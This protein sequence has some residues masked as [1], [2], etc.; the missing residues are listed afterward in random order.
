MNAIKNA[1]QPPIPVSISLTWHT[2]NTFSSWTKTPSLHLY[3]TQRASRNVAM[4]RTMKEEFI[5][6]A[7]AVRMKKRHGVRLNH[8]CLG[9]SKAPSSSSSSSSKGAMGPRPSHHFLPA[10]MIAKAGGEKES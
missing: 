8:A 10:L 3:L 1:A 2:V 6:R 5:R 9:P 4:K 7:R